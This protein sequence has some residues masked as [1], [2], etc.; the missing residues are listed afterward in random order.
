MHMEVIW[1]LKSSAEIMAKCHI[2]PQNTP[3]TSQTE[4]GKEMVYKLYLN[5]TWNSNPCPHHHPNKNENESQF[6]LSFF[7][8]IL[9]A[10]PRTTPLYQKYII[11]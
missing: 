10:I 8:L 11:K 9:E 1:W 2:A 5:K 4:I 3:E 7:H 6:V